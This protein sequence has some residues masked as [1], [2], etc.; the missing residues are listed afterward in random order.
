MGSQFS[1]N[2]ILVVG[3]NQ[4]VCP[5]ERHLFGGNVTH[6]GESHSAEREPILRPHEASRCALY[7]FIFPTGAPAPRLA[8][9]GP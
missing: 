6:H 1:I 8:S 4:E 2:G 7:P 9:P 3:T 5:H